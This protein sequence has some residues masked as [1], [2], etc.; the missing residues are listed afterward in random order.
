MPL[1]PITPYN[2]AQRAAF[3]ALLVGAPPA[4]ITTVLDFLD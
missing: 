2:P 3:A 1:P 4:N